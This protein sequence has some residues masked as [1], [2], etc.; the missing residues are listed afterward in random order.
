MRKCIAFLLAAC[1]GIG[2]G[3]ILSLLFQITA[4]TDNTMMPSLS[5][6][7]KVLV[8]RTAYAGE[9]SPRRGDI[10]LF[11]NYVYAATGENSV[12]MKRVVGVAG[13]T[14]LIT[15]G[16]VYVNN[17]ALEEDYV[18]TQDVSGEMDQVQ[19]PRGKVFVLGDNRAGSTDSRS[20]TV[21]LV[22]VEAIQGKVI[23]QW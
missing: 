22:D 16:K 13:D 8:S 10:V 7:D 6:G 9:N 15:G 20:E 21:G 14:V 19:V 18:F 5:E 3:V 11:P 2:A 17:K 1:L 23:Y 4:V 12:M